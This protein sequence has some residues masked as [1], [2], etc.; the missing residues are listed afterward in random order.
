MYINLTKHYSCRICLLDRC[1]KS[2][3]NLT[4]TYDSKIKVL[5]VQNKNESI[6]ERKNRFSNL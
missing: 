1:D 4:V 6:Q 3:I 2:K 5:N